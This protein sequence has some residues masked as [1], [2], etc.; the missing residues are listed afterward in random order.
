MIRTRKIRTYERGL[1]FRDGALERVLETGRHWLWDPLMNL[2]I[3]VVSVRGPWLVHN[4]LEV[5]VRSEALCDELQ[6]ID[7]KDEQRALVW[8]D[9]RLTTVLKPG[10]YA[11]WTVFH[12]VRVEL[13]DASEARLQ[14]EDLNVLLEAEGAR[15]AIATE[16]V[17]QG[18]VGL[19]FVDGELRGALGP[20]RHA[21]WR[22]AGAV[23]VSVIDLRSQMLDIS[24]QEIITA[25]KVSLR[26]NAV[27]TY[28]VADAEQAVTAVSDYSQSLYRDAQLALRSVIG[29]RELE[30]LLADKTTV[31]AELEGL[32]VEK[33]RG[34]GVEVQSLGIRDVILPGEMRGLLN[35]VTEAKKAAEAA[36]ITRREETAAMRSQAN[37]A[38]LLEQSPTLMRL[39]ELETLERVA[40]D[41]DLTVVMGEGGLTERV[42]KLL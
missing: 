8:I 27:V 25:D 35:K 20:G 17:A 3:D 36:V 37:T 21:F 6:V 26:I 30:S 28:R 29:T 24:G 7:L 42:T 31:A 11:L 32:V 41:A 38:R 4:D 12:D 2:R 33:A 34:Y 13:L 23:R 39:R 18:Q 22:D 15:T 16:T 5:L 1:V 10:L 9:G 14:R 19:L 40:S